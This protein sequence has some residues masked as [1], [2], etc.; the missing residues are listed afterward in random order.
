MSPVSY[1]IYEQGMR[2]RGARE[3]AGHGGNRAH[4]N[5]LGGWH[6][7][8]VEQR[9]HEEGLGVNSTLPIASEALCVGRRMKGVFVAL[10]F[11]RAR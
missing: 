1:Q 5:I 11:R 6:T 2:L 9:P 7:Y 10:L 3:N 8:S 4:V